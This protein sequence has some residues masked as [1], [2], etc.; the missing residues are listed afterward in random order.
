MADA[1]ELAL[2]QQVLERANQI[3]DANL[4]NILR[5]GGVGEQYGFGIVKGTIEQIQQLFA[6]LA[7]SSF[8][9]VPESKLGTVNQIAVDV[10]TMFDQYRKFNPLNLQNAQATLEALLGAPKVQL[11]KTFDA[12]TPILALSETESTDQLRTLLTREMDGMRAVRIEASVAAAEI[13]ETAQ[14]ARQAAEQVGIAEHAIFFRDESDSHKKS[15]FWWLLLT[16]ALTSIAALIGWKNY[17]GTLQA[18]TEA[19]S[20][21]AAANPPQTP[22]FTSLQIQL[23]IGKLILFSIIFSAVIWSGKIYRT[24]RH[25]FIVNRHRFNALRTFETFA[26]ST[27]DEQIKNA[28]LLQATQCIFGPQPTG[29]ISGENENDGYPQVL[30]IVRG[31]GAGDKK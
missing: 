18:L 14:K 26:K 22:T 20:H 1:L 8:E 28:V 3:A 30:E 21:A 27:K 9:L 6:R 11:L 13:K 15:A 4:D 12:I 10:L 5:F 16:L 23:T 2:R 7:K 17:S 31:M 25:N 24:H 19:V 29:Y